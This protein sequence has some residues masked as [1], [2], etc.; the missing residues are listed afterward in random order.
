M[1]SKITP[2][3]ARLGTAFT[4]A[5]ASAGC[6]TLQTSNL[7]EGGCKVGVSTQSQLLLIFSATS[8]SSEEFSKS[9][10]EGKTAAYTSFI[11][12]NE[13]NELS[14][15]GALFALEYHKLLQEKIETGKEEEKLFFKDVKNYF[16]HFLNVGGTNIENIKKYVDEL[17]ESAKKRQNERAPATPEQSSVSAPPQPAPRCSGDIFRVCR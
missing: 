16:N 12:R 8:T 1:N 9:C 14:I 7:H 3:L 5:A 10:S 2:I 11:G 13:K 15:G 17:I 4:I 6:S